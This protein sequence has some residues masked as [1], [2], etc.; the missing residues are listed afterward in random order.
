MNEPK[1]QGFSEKAWRQPQAFLARTGFHDLATLIRIGVALSCAFVVGSTAINDWQNRTSTLSSAEVNAQNLSQ[2]LEENIKSTFMAIEMVMNLVPQPRIATYDTEEREGLTGTLSRA[3]EKMPVIR[4]M[5]IRDAVSRAMLF[6]FHRTPGD[7]AELESLTAEPLEN[8]AGSAFMMSK[9]YRSGE[10]RW[11]LRF[12]NAVTKEA[13][14]VHVIVTVDLDELNHMIS[15]TMIGQN[16]ASTVMRS[17]GIVLARSPRENYIGRDLST[18][19]MFRL[20]HPDHLN[21]TFRAHSIA[22][23]VERISS[24]SVLPYFGFIAVTGFSIDEILLRWW[25][26]V[27]YDAVGAICTCAIF[28]LFGRLLLEAVARNAAIRTAL[29]R[30]SEQ[31]QATLENIDQGLVK[32]DADGV[33]AVYNRRFSEL[34]DV[35]EAF[36]STKPHFMELRKRLI[37][38]QEYALSD[39]VFKQ[40]V[41]SSS[42]SPVDAVY[43]RVRPNGTILE[44]R[45]VSLAGGGA[46]R[47]YTDI[48]ARK[49]GEQALAESES[50]YRLLSE[51]A[52]D[53]IVFASP[54]RKHRYISPA[55]TAMLGYSIDEGIELTIRNF[56]HPD[57]ANQVRAVVWS[58]SPENPRGNTVFRMKRKDG[59]YIWV[60]SSLQYVETDDGPGAVCVVRDI[61]KRRETEAALAEKT[62]ILQVTLDT[63]DQGLLMIDA[64]RRVRIC[65]RRAIELLDLPPLLMCRNPHMDEVLQH[66]LKTQDFLHQDENFVS[67]VKSGGFN[68]HRHSY[69]RERPNGSVLDI[70][71]IPIAHGGWVRT[72]TD[73]TERKEVERKITHSSRHDVLTDL[74]N[75]LLFRERLEQLI[76]ESKRDSKSFAVLYID[77]DRFKAVND[78]L[79][80]LIGDILLKSVTARLR[81]T[82]RKEDTIARLGGDEFAVLHCG[83]DLADT[84]AP[85]AQRLISA[86]DEPFVIEG[87]SVSVGTSIGIALA[88]ENGT[89]ADELLRAADRA[90]YRAK[91]S[92]RNGYCFFREEMDAEI[93]ARRTLELDLRHALEN[94]ELHLVFQPVMSVADARVVSC[95]ALLRWKHPVHGSV[96]PATF[97]PLAEETGLIVSIGDWVLHEACK[98]ASNWDMPLGIAV[99]VSAIQFGAGL[100]EKIAAALAATGLAPER[101]EIEITESVLIQ[102]GDQVLAALKEIRALGVRIALDDFGT[103]FSSLSYL[104]RF[105][106]DTIKIDKSFIREIEEPKT[107]A[108]IDSIVNLGERFC[109]NITAEGV[110]TVR[111]LELV[112]A[113]GCTHVQG[114][115]L[116]RPIDAGEIEQFVHG[117]TRLTEAA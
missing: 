38:N 45:S 64:E 95:E 42:L 31:L 26:G 111:E 62:T 52:S 48:T 67:W 7:K 61:T 25:S 46:V 105:P 17:D 100:C 97:I 44:V 55:V 81:A 47:T 107:S 24:Y 35:D 12:A 87:H 20:K 86:L 72:Y 80:H 10:G 89:D 82:L 88:P 54:N 11:L 113:K 78:S 79:G 28:C 103:G 96:S 29:E 27:I 90:L 73:I 56:A 75:R 57:D 83:R 99:N 1:R 51:N 76:A 112:C 58:L 40:W 43:E 85:V 41:S 36:L 22:D 32:I 110:E 115:L 94:G 13:D 16:G 3:T 63:M 8:V 69:E 14:G 53:L 77:L 101:L 92:G 106:F 116:S 49:L 34:L 21:G 104:R 68:S 70:T 37:A 23:N 65:N 117:N 39:P 9:P 109:V 33:V 66:Q 6:D 84:V 71:T 5:E 114:Y 15:R 50:R 108:I 4:A 18:G 91:E 30:N 2:L 98:V 60:E 59:S 93:V 19:T 74:P 102:Q